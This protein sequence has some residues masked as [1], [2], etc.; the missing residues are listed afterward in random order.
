MATW[1]DILNEIRVSGSNY[2]ILRRTYLKKLADLRNRNV[3]VYYSG[4]L[5]KPHLMN[6]AGVNVAIHDGDKN[7]FMSVIKGMDRT[8]GLDLILHTPGGD[9][10][11]TESLVDYLRSMFGTDICAFVPQL[12]MSGGTMIACACKEIW[13]GKES[14]LGPIDPQVGNLPATAILEEFER[15][16]REIK[17]DS[18]KALV[19]QPIINKLAPSAITQC[20][21]AIRWGTQV[22]S[23]WLETAM[24][25]DRVDAAGDAA[26][27]VADLTDKAKNHTHGRHLNAETAKSYGLEIR[28]LEDDQGLQDAVLSVHHANCVTLEATRAYKIIENQD[29]VAFI[30]LVQQLA[31]ATP[32]IGNG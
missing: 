1:N 24:F 6:E 19:W 29:G 5:Q 27:T 20:E 4:W 18:T 3:I 17:A 8:K 15:A 31:I 28:M 25:K 7:G 13:M 32:L 12:A 26:K 10:A 30:Q 2:D 21:D 22:A 23:R 14:S 11:A 9:M 16:A